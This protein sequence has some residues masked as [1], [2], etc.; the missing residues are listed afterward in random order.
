[1]PLYTE[2][3]SSWRD[4]RALPSFAP[5]LP[6]LSPKHEPTEDGI[7]RYEVVIVGVRKPII[8]HLPETLPRASL[9]IPPPLIPVLFPPGRP[10]RPHAPHAP[11]P[12]RAH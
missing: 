7:E 8:T 6:R 4:L 1:M 2:Q 5:P 11:R 10:S 12:L 9:S 3:A